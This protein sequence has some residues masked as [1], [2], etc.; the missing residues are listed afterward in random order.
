MSAYGAPLGVGP[1]K[2]NTNWWEFL[3]LSQSGEPF[4]CMGDDYVEFGAVDPNR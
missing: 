3:T 2:G 4:S 1:D